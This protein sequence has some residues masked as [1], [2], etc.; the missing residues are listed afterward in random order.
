MES[1]STTLSGFSA[2]TRPGALRLQVEGDGEAEGHAVRLDALIVEFLT[3]QPLE[4]KA[5]IPVRLMLGEASVV[6]QIRVQHVQPGANTL[7]EEGWFHS[8]TWKA[9]GIDKARLDAFLAQNRGPGAG[10]SPRRKKVKGRR[11]ITSSMLRAAERMST[12]RSS[13]EGREPL[14]RRLPPPPRPDGRRVRGLPDRRQPVA[15]E[16]LIAPTLA[17]D[18]QHGLLA[19]VPDL[20]TLHLALELGD[21]WFRLVVARV[22]LL[23]VGER[24]HLILVLPG[25]SYLGQETAVVRCGPHR[26]VLQGS[27][28]PADQLAVLRA[29][30]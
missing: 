29:G 28:V 12:V 27:G 6:V 11:S 25:G 2:K 30:G 14:N 20:N 9:R 23:E 8:G 19:P 3:D 7:Y 17:Q 22:P 15:P 18:G 5:E 24:V 26:M 16:A 10:F 13:A 1:S 21:D 4:E